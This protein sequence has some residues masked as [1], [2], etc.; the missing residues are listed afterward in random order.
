M[1]IEIPTI[2]EGWQ[3]DEQRSHERL[4]VVRNLTRGCPCTGCPG[5]T[6]CGLSGHECAGFRDWVQRG[7]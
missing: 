3:E 6:A 5:K 2:A 1:T 7:K 4:K